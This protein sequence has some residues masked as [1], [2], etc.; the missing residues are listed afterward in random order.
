VAG[1]G[2]VRE[3]E[4]FVEWHGKLY[5]ISYAGG[6]TLTRLTPP[7]DLKLGTWIVNT[8]TLTG[9]TMAQKF[10]AA[11]TSHYTNLISVPAI[12]CLAWVPGGNNPVY[13]MK[14]E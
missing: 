1:G 11:T 9:P 5:H 3:R 12:D 4:R 2:S 14:P 7:A 8:V 10:G 13:I 6:N